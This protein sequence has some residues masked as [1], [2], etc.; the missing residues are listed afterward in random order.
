MVEAWPARPHVDPI[1]SLTNRKASARGRPAKVTVGGMQQWLVP[2]HRV[3]LRAEKLIRRRSVMPA[4][5]PTEPPATVAVL[6]GA[7][8]LCR[9]RLSTPSRLSRA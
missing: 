1:G 8:V 2:I 9:W 6:S 5:G 7:A 3:H 4:V